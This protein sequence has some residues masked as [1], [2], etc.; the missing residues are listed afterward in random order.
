MYQ[1][2]C[3]IPFPYTFKYDK[4][5][6]YRGAVIPVYKK[7][8]EAQRMNAEEVLESVAAPGHELGD[9]RS[10]TSALVIQISI[11][12]CFDASWHLPFSYNTKGGGSNALLKLQLTLKS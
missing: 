10:Q 6:K 8:I 3:N 7:E 1:K 12:K 4:R 5:D 9:P 2:P 11:L